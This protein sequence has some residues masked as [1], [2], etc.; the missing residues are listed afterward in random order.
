MKI[1]HLQAIVKPIFGRA[2][3]NLRQPV[4]S[5]CFLVFKT[6]LKSENQ[7]QQS[8]V[9]MPIAQYVQVGAAI[10]KWKVQYFVENMKFEIV[11]GQRPILIFVW[12][13]IHFWKAFWKLHPIGGRV[14][15]FFD[16]RYNTTGPYHKWTNWPL[17][18]S[19]VLL[20]WSY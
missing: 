12:S 2:M 11:P 19:L 1:V 7:M 4:W 10:R 16:F 13:V 17:Q 5:S 3:T 9:M 8:G 6:G 14:I 18:G 15:W 20:L